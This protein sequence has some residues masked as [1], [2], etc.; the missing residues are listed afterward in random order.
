M[1]YDKV[2]FVGEDNT[3][4]SPMAETIFRYAFGDEKI[5]C[6]VVS[7]GLVVL[8]EEPYNQKAEMILYNHGMET[9]SKSAVQLDAAEL[10]ERVLVLTMTFPEKLKIIEDYGFGGSVY[11]LKEYIGNDDELLDPYGEEIDIYEACFQD[12]F[13]AIREVKKLFV[14]ENKEYD[15][16]VNGQNEFSDG[17]IGNNNT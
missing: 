5:G 15:D 6:E 11:T 4:R 3:C 1:K 10:A 16:A 14:K 9:V 7:R 13:A 8:F 12:M 17:I 2:I